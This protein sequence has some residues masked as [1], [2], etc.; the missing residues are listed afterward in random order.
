MSFITPV[1]MVFLAA[2]IGVLDVQVSVVGSYA[3]TAE[4]R[5]QPGPKAPPTT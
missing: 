5:L 1:A 4:V 2:G 3:S